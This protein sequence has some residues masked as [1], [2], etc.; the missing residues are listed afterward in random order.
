MSVRPALTSSI[1]GLLQAGGA[2][3]RSL[4]AGC[5]CTSSVSICRCSEWEEES[6]A[7]LGSELGCSSNDHPSSSLTE[8]GRCTHFEAYAMETAKVPRFALNN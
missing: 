2:S 7:A 1:T 3:I 6:S 4:L 8:E 5:F